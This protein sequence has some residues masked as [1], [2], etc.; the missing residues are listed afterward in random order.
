MAKT[1]VRLTPESV[2]GMHIYEDEKGRKIYYKPRKLIGYVIKPENIKT[3]TTLSNR[4][5]MS[6]LA[7]IFGYF[8]L[9]TMKLPVWL[10]IPIA[11]VVLIFLEYRFHYKFLPNLVQLHNFVPKSKPSRLSSMALQDGWRLQAKAILYPIFGILLEYEFYL[12]HG[13]NALVLGIG[14]AIL[15]VTLYISFLNIRAILYKKKQPDTAMKKN[16]K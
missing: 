14:A 13:W 10:A 11:I 7:G 8:I 15:V 1:D 3:Y 9:D 5:L 12:Q 16:D 2:S 6:G 4:Y